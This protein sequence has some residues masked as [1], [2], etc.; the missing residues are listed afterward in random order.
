MSA[1]KRLPQGIILKIDKV[2][3]EKTAPRALNLFYLGNY[4]DSQRMWRMCLVFGKITQFTVGLQPKMRTGKN[5]NC[6]EM[7][8]VCKEQRP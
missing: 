6:R 1:G 4:N 3:I 5:E 8:R 2:C 7:D